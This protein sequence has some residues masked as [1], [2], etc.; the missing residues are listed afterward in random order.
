ME[1]AQF[2][3]GAGNHLTIGM[4]LGEEHESEKRA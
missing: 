2:L 1:A 3:R 4:K